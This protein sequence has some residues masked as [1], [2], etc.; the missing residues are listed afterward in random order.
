MQ[1]Y[2]KVDE[3]KDRNKRE[4]KDKFKDEYVKVDEFKDEIKDEYKSG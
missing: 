3:I 2:V 4:D 1:S